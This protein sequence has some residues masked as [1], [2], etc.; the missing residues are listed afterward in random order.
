MNV[1]LSN[2]IKTIKKKG[3]KN[4]QN[5]CNYFD[6]LVDSKALQLPLFEEEEVGTLSVLGFDVVGDSDIFVLVVTESSEENKNKT[7]KK[8]TA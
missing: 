7:K 1:W 4:K 2:K 5:I 3:K 8:K 6:L